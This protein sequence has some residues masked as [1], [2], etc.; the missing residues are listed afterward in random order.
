M[1][2]TRNFLPCVLILGLSLCAPFTAKSGSIDVNGTCEVGCS[3]QQFLS[4]GM[5]DAGAFNF[6]YTFAD[7]DVYDI[8]G[9]YSASYSTLNGST[10]AIDPEFTY[11]G[12]SPSVKNDTLDLSFSQ[13]YFDTSC[14]TW[15]GTYTESVPLSLGASAGPKSTISG[16]LLYDGKS[17]GLVGPFGPGTYFV[18]QSANLDFG[19][20]DDSPDLLG[21][22]QFSVKFA[23]GALP[24]ASAGSTNTPEPVT[25]LLC[26]LG[27]IMLGGFARSRKR[28]GKTS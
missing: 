7:G 5:S 25:P 2:S 3:S 24:G 13:G 14:C 8:F 21:D 1:T 17:V 22:Y 12:T 15:A 6:L 9:N 4:N 20:L 28:S 26:G 18:T 16:Q 27:L 23:R 10:I 19:A 11:E